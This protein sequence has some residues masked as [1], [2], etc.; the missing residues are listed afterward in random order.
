MPTAFMA[1]DVLQQVAFKTWPVGSELLYG[2]DASKKKHAQAG[3]D[4]SSRDRHRLRLGPGI[5]MSRCLGDL[6]DANAGVV[7][8]PGLGLGLGVRLRG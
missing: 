4:S 5:A 6:L 3:V 2:Y 1:T 8:S 7:S